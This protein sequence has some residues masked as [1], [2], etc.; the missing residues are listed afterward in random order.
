[1]C[2]DS[3]HSSSSRFVSKELLSLV[4][5]TAIPESATPRDAATDA[6]AQ[7]RRPF[8]ATSL[9]DGPREPRAVTCPCLNITPS[10]IRPWTAC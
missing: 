8:A 10:Q 4:A 9:P 5:D 3:V 6:D 7:V 2:G 1:M